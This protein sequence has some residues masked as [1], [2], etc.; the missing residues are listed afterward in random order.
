MNQIKN[1]W[2]KLFPT[3]VHLPAGVYSYEPLPGEGFPY[4]L[5]LR[6]EPDGNGILI[7]NAHTVL[8]LNSSAA[9]YAWHMIQHSSED[10]TVKDITHRYN[11]GRAQAGQDFKEFTDKLQAFLESPD[12]DPETYLDFGRHE[13]YSAKLSAPYRLDCALTYK[14]TDGDGKNA[15]VS[16]VTREMVTEEWKTI[17]EKAWNA[18]IPHIVFTGGE[19]TMRPDLVD[20]ISYAGQLGQVTGLLTDGLRLS[21]GKYLHELLQSGLD[22]LM[23][24]LDP[25]ENQCWE[26]I[27]DVLAEDIFL[28]VHMTLTKKNMGKTLT[29][30][31]RLASMGAK[32][33][34]L[35]SAEPGL[36]EELKS[37][38]EAAAVKE[39]A[40][41]W[42]LPVPYS[43]F[44]PILLELQ[45]GEKPPQGAGNAWLY[46]EPDGDVLPAQGI[47]E[48]LGNLLTD[49][50]KEIWEKSNPQ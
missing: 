15:P 32:S 45:E 44:N 1:L 35:S 8:H 40:I 28:T 42:D 3:S 27:R 16:R 14:T 46:V 23:I 4:R 36:A 7:L 33:I 34:S 21:D 39:L 13:P 47:N 25:L 9:E 19:P 6:V 37:L 43:T 41:E 12:L 5:L 2:Q 18:G 20:L 22:H 48:R 17:L 38:R 50:W 30:L 29:A 11:I 31:D 24:T 10:E 26:C 49:S